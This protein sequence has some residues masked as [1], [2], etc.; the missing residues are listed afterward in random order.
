MRQ[1][2]PLLW[3]V[4]L[5]AVALLCFLKEGKAE[6]TPLVQASGIGSGSSPRKTNELS[7]DPPP[8]AAKALT[9]TAPA[10]RVPEPESLVTPEERLRVAIESKNV[11]VEFW[12]KVV[13]QNDTPLAGV[14]LHSQIRHWDFEPSRGLAQRNIERAMTT[15]AD[16]R[17]HIGGSTGDD[18]IIKMEKDG[19]ELE[20]DAQLGFGYG[21]SERFTAL[22]EA[23]MIFK[24]WPTNIHERLIVGS[25]RFHVVPDGRIYMIDLTT[26]TMAESGGG[27]LKI[28]LK[29]PAEVA[30]G[31]TNDWS[32][33]VEAVNG[34][35]LEETNARSS[36]YLA[37]VTGYTPAF[38]YAQR[39]RGGQSGSTGKKRFYVMLKNGQE[40]GRVTLELIAPYNHQVPGLVRIDYAINPSGPRI[41]R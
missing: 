5:F 1:I 9:P 17:F 31:Q 18:L 4:A 24:M 2:K 25:K 10:R 36:M 20:P 3:E 15:G 16:G 39:L 7:V 27:D 32:A 28:T 34:G 21:T 37:P 6:P 19:Y 13:D 38:R 29:H 8:V 14:K 22:P 40:Y 23:P 33:E 30:R 12:G 41:L 26:G 35:L 11:P